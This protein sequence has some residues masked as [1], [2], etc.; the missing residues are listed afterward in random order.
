MKTMFGRGACTHPTAEISTR[1]RARKT[2]RMAE[3]N[4]GRGEFQTFVASPLTVRVDSRRAMK[5]RLRL[6]LLAAVA[7][8][9]ALVAVAQE[10]QHHGLVFEE[11]IDDTFFGG[12]RPPSYT[13]KWDI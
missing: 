5:P 4:P 7:F 10:V 8:V 12:Y 11:W 9:T 2:R 3:A 1:S 6:P 13:Q